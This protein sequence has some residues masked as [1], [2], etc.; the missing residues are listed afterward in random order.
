M[1]KTEIVQVPVID[2][3]ADYDVVVLGF[4]G[5]GATAARF[6][7]DHGAKVLIADIAPYGHEGG[8]TR[9]AAQL[10][11]SGN[12]YE[13]LKK[14]YLGLTHPM[15][16]PKD[17]VELFVKGMLH[18]KD[19]VKKYLDAEPVSF[20]KDFDL[21]QAYKAAACQEY[22]N[23]PGHKTYDYIMVHKGWFDAA[24]WKILRQKVLDRK[25]KIDVWY[26]ARAIHLFQ[27][28][29]T[30]V[31]KGAQIVKDGQKI[32]VLARKGVVL[33]TGGFE[34][35]K[36][37]IQ[38]YLGAPSLSPL[39]TVY[40]K[41]DGIKMAQE[42]GAKMWHMYNYEA[43]GLMH[44]LSFATPEG[45]RSEL[46]LQWD[47]LNHGSIFMIADDGRRYFNETEMNRHGHIFDHGMWR[48]PR[49]H[50]KPYLVFDQKQYQEIEKHPLQYDK[51]NDKLVKADTL[52]D[53]ASKIG[54]DAKGLE[55]QV[56]LFNKYAKQ[57]KD[58]QFGR[59]PESMTAFTD[60]PFYAIKMGYN[61]L[62]T[63]GGPERNTKAEIL[64][65]N[66]Q[67][68][69]HLYGAGELGGICANQYQGGG[70][71]AECLIFGKIA[72]EQ[73][74][75]NKDEV[76]EAA[77]T[78]YN[79]INELADGDQIKDVKL[80]K[81]QYLGSSDAGIGGK[82][83]VRVTYDDNK[84]KNVEVVQNH[85]SEDIGKKALEVIPKR[86]VEKNSADVDAVSGASATS[87]AISEAVNKALKNK[88]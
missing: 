26:E 54:V 33:T 4:G 8:N 28:P 39:G 12:D 37:M 10:I 48:V 62:N 85:E 3:K 63:Q 29:V 78:Q 61:V 16:L 15:D 14:Y 52:S 42:V 9:Y 64:D 18:T 40:N 67:P 5:A 21:P 6:A 59:D 11:G 44:G 1:S 22:P 87:R 60:G 56:K 41:G 47:Q 58:E 73:A 75:A 88:K 68:I 81:D 30:K 76:K 46:F 55:E 79:G 80:G 72:G 53:L 38:A 71:L 13:E 34:D 20:M 57:K 70:N 25:N 86:I 36:K 2:W 84:I 7:A 31:V 23:L 65:T 74:A 35:N 82:L 77:S 83:V 69:P 51:F 17:M 43:L 24:L 66:N 19:Y 45:Q 27:D 32:N 49:T 50:E